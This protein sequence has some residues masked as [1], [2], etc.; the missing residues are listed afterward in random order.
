MTLDRTVIELLKA[1]KS[2]PLSSTSKDKAREA[3]VLAR[4]HGTPLTQ[5][6]NYDPDYFAFIREEQS[7]EFEKRMSYMPRA[8]NE[9]SS[10]NETTTQNIES[11]S[12]ST[13]STNSGSDDGG[14]CCCLMG[15]GCLTAIVL[16]TMVGFASL[17]GLA[18]SYN[19]GSWYSKPTPEYST[20]KVPKD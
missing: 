12:E 15:C 18:L 3:F 6:E 13:D 17:T 2:D 16:S 10:D 4:R 5:Y 1:I 7:E 14:C 8:S 11:Q 19:F 9:E 20:H